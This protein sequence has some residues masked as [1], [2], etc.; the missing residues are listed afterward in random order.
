MLFD[1]A[2][3]DISKMKEVTRKFIDAYE[4]GTKTLPTNVGHLPLGCDIDYFNTYSHF[5]IHY[6]ML[7]VSF[8]Y[9]FYFLD[10]GTFTD[11]LP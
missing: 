9:I 2:M 4:G 5:G 11:Q 10:L 3:K 7:T 8:F 1:N 6:E